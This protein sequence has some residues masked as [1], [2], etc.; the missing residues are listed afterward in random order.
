[1]SC[2]IQEFDVSS[3][4]SFH[5]GKSSAEFSSAVHLIGDAIEAV[6]TQA[7]MGLPIVCCVGAILQVL[8]A[9]VDDSILDMQLM[10]S[11]FTDSYKRQECPNHRWRALPLKPQNLCSCRI[12]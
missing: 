8:V 9:C 6:M 1:M 2:L 4:H 5:C 3:I 12:I 11:M 7:D 10:H